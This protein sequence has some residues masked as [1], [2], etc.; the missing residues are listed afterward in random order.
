MTK[1]ELIEEVSAKTGLSKAKSK[2]AIEAAIEAVTE[3]LAKGGEVS[4]IG[5]GTFKVSERAGREAK[6]P[7]TGKIM[8]IPPTKTVRFKVGKTLKEA[9]AGKK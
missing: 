5:F 3:T 4:L 1:K 8:K 7:S 6:V 9:V 2:E